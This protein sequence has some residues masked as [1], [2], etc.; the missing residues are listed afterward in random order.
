MKL[1]LAALACAATIPAQALDRAHFRGMSEADFRYVLTAFQKVSVHY[2]VSAEGGSL[3]TRML[4]PDPRVNGLSDFAVFL[5]ADP[6]EAQRAKER[7]DQANPDRAQLRSAP[8]ARILRQQFERR[9]APPSQGMHEPDFVIFL[10]R[11]ELLL[12]PDEEPVSITTDGD[13][14]VVYAY[15]DPSKAAP[16]QKGLE[17]R[18]LATK[19]VR[20]REAAF[21]RFIVEQAKQKRFVF[22]QGY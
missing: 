13:K 19:R 3:F 12:Q 2:L 22:V 11:I 14:E 16:M 20:I 5:Y 9:D 17:A 10:E 6:R 1:L 7:Y 21:L 18:G 15:L 4:K 8:A